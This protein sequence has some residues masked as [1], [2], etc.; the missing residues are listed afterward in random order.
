MESENNKVHMKELIEATAEKLPLYNK[1][2]IKEIITVFMEELRDSI[3]KNHQVSLRGFFT[4][5]HRLVNE[6]TLS[7]FGDPIVYPEHVA[8]KL[9]FS[10]N[11]ILNPLNRYYKKTNKEI[12]GSLRDVPIDDDFE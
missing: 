1:K 11:H 12:P 9:T 6:K 2:A 3:I 5:R 4:F 8:V 7:N 10:K